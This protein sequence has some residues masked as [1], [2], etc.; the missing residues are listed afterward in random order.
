MRIIVD[1]ILGYHSNGKT[2]HL[3]KVAGD[4]SESLP[5][6]DSINGYI[7][8]GSAALMTDTGETMLYNEKTSAW[9]KVTGVTI[10]YP[11]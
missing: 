10:S 6:N 7:V 8:D 4:S 2:L 11:F 5:N 3:I 9:K 1:Y